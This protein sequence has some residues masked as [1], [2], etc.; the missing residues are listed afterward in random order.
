MSAVLTP[1]AEPKLDPFRFGVRLVKRVGSNGEVKFVEV[2]MTL[3]DA[4]H[5]Q[6]GDRYMITTA[7]NR[8]SIY[9]QNVFA[10][11]M[12]DVPGAMVL[13][14]QRVA[15]DAKGE[16]YHGPDV[17]VL[18]NVA[19][20][21]DWKTFNVAQEK[22]TPILIV[23]VV[24]AS[25]RVNDVE[26]KV[27][28]YATEGVSRYVIVDSDES[29]DQRNVSFIHY[30]LA[31]RGKKFEPVPIP[32]DGR[33]WLPEVNLWLTAEND[34]V[35]C[36]RANGERV[37]PYRE[38]AES[39]SAVEKEARASERARLK[40]VKAAAEAD[41]RAAHEA[42]ARAEAERIVAVQAD[43]IRRLQAQVPPSS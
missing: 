36:Y 40:A 15:W 20:E 10:A 14:D 8:D 2:P 37:Q 16:R 28:E 11:A 34:R 39:K 22:A 43:L 25:T 29:G 17:I 21:K 27:V 33:I 19:K 42:E 7:H 26:T 24:S 35:V 6:E 41:Q 30:Q 13:G 18:L 3:E 31:K 9:L 32:E 23:E 5:P 12:A 4:L 38:L 1:K